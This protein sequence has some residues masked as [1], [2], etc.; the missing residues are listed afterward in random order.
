MYLPPAFRIEDPEK[1]ARFIAHHSFATVVTQGGDGLFASHLPLLHDAGARRL[2]GHLARANP[3]WRHFADG[4]EVLVIFGGPH[5]YISPRWYETQPAVPTWN[6]GVVHV[7]GAPRVMTDAAELAD[8]L[9]RT[10]RFYEGDGPEA[11][12]GDLPAEFFDRMLK[13]IVG[14]E[15]AITRVEAKFKLGQNRSPAD[16]AG[17][18]AALGRSPRAGDRA[19]AEFMRQEGLAGPEPAG[20]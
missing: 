4:R 7:Y 2:T 9:R 8:V 5:A 11:W 10:I 20:A 16:A 13:A 18:L 15:I 3:Q 6:Y 12:R 1:I 14:F 17:M 19:L